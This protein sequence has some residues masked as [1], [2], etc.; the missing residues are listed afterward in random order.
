MPW[1]IED[2]NQVLDGLGRLAELLTPSPIDAPALSLPGG[3]HWSRLHDA[4]GSVDAL[5]WLDPW[6]RHN[7]ER[8]AAQEADFDQAAAG[9]TLVHTDIR[10]DNVLLTG[11][12]AVF[13]DWPHAAVG[14]A[15]IDLLYF[16]PSVAMQG[17]PEPNETFWAHPVSTIADSDAMLAVLAGITGFFV[18]CATLP[19]PPG[20][21]TLRRFQAGQGQHAV[22]WLRRLMA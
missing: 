19:A 6:V 4:P 11:E 15:W 13:V 14:A 18:H 12:G 16:L 3:R 10:A 20:L 21:P 22:A 5:D 9:S 7:L 1:R 8:L 2:L 17:G